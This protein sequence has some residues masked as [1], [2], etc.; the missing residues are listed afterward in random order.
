MSGEDTRA[1]VLRRGLTLT[2]SELGVSAAELLAIL[3][4][5]PTS[6]DTFPEYPVPAEYTP[7]TGSQM[8]ALQVALARADDSH[9]VRAPAL[10]LADLHDN[11]SASTA[12]QPVAP[13]TRMRPEA[14]PFYAAELL[15]RFPE[16]V[17]GGATVWAYAPEACEMVPRIVVADGRYGT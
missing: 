5:G 9:V 12:A 10:D 14:R 8:N 11:V 3:A 1:W 2:A 6:L 15:R 4:T 16:G 7:L 13:G 17:V